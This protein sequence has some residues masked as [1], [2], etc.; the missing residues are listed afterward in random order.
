MTKLLDSVIINNIKKIVKRE[1]NVTSYTVDIGLTVLSDLKRC[2]CL[3]MK[4][5]YTFNKST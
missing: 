1:V 5:E 3:F 2:S 4:T